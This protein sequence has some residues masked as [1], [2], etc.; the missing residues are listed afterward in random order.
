M[1]TMHSL[2]RPPPKEVAAGLP[3][4]MTQHHARGPPCSIAREAAGRLL[5]DCA[6]GARGRAV[7]CRSRMLS[8]PD[9]ARGHGPNVLPRDVWFLHHLQKHG[10]RLWDA[11]GRASACPVHETREPET[12]AEDPIAGKAEPACD[13]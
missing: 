7:A 8:L 6:A 9:I 1:D 2:C 11:L 4:G 3:H 13:D 12:V 5:D 10:W